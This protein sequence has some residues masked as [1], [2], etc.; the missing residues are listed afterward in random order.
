MTSMFLTRHMS[1]QMT[2]E[3]STIRLF[4]VCRHFWAFCQHM[5]WDMFGRLW[6]SHVSMHH[7][8][9]RAKPKNNNDRFCCLRHKSTWGEFS[10]L[11]SGMLLIKWQWAFSSIFA[12]APT[13]L[14]AMSK[15][16][17][18]FNLDLESW[19]LVM[20]CARGAWCRNH[21]VNRGQNQLT[22]SISFNFYVPVSLV[23]SSCHV[24]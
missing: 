17:L 15:Y 23:E 10:T 3:L 1:R 24:L 12:P 19:E 7:C 21:K 13:R 18:K 9:T 11:S 22:I 14:I 2:W 20:T 4:F 8:C 5:T 6:P 16:I